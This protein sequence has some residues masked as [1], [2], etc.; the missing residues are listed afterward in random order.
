MPAAASGQAKPGTVE[1][2]LEVAI[3]PVSDVDRAKQFYENL[4]WRLDA[5]FPISAELRV[6]QFT[7][8]GSKASIIFGKGVGD[9]TPGAMERLVLVVDDIEAA[10]ADLVA[11][12]VDV[13]EIFHG[14]G[15]GKGT[16]GRVPGVDA[17]R[18]SYGSF[19]LFSDPDGN[20]WLLQEITD[21]LPGRV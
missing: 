7:P 5:D 4:G 16:M 20:P 15:F 12:N 18:T 10:R 6:I 1:M 13:S 9:A 19:A 3:I 17:H 14:F 8:T 21:R 2:K 11:R